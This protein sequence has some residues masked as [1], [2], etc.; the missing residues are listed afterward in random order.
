VNGHDFRFPKPAG[1]SLPLVAEELDTRC[2]A[3][4]AA[5]CAACLAAAQTDLRAALRQ[6]V[7]L[8]P[9][10]YESVAALATRM[11]SNQAESDKVMAAFDGATPE[12][13]CLPL[14]G[15]RLEGPSASLAL[16]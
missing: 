13:C 16:C 9:T 15:I 6:S 5:A 1:P 2:L 8:C 10:H 11:A 3:R 4:F 7:K 14:H 12:M